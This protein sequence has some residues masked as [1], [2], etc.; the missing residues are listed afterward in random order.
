MTKHLR[1]SGYGLLLQMLLATVF[2]T[3]TAS[4][5]GQPAPQQILVLKPLTTL[6][7]H[8]D[9]GQIAEAHTILRALTAALDNPNQK[10][11]IS[12][13]EW[14]ELEFLR[15]RLAMAEGNFEAAVPI[16]ENILSRY[17]DIARVR[18]ELGMAFFNLKQDQRAHYQFDLALQA[19]LPRLAEA[20]IESV[21]E[22]MYRR[23][24]WQV[25]MKFSLVPDSN[26][27]AATDDRTVSLFG[28]PFVLNENATEQS[29]IG[30]LAELGVTN[31]IHLSTNLTLDSSASV[32][33]IEYAGSRFDDT[34]IS[35]YSGPRHATNT[36]AISLQFGGFRRWFGEGGF[37]RGIGTQLGSYQRIGQKW[38]TG[39]NASLFWVNYD[40]IAPR[41]GFSLQ[42]EPFLVR[43]VGASGHVRA[44]VNYNQDFA[45]EQNQASITYQYGL[46]FVRELP[47]DLRLELNGAYGTRQFQAAQASFGVRRQD[48]FFSAGLDIAFR[49]LQIL[50]AALEFSYKFEKADSNISL[51][52]YSRHRFEVGLTKEF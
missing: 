13:E 36:S 52:S 46:R 38:A 4:A 27:N 34:I 5:E 12:V 35:F 3:I 9:Q 21:K 48:E 25:R 23:R 14:I 41:T 11:A 20:R 45:R 2:L 15:G 19:T 28:L 39:I 24:K 50:D 7:Q 37:N 17:P 47:M 40:Q 18:L 49:K 1:L 44:H 22:A 51:F 8:I 29:G 42:A 30:A 32:R 6:Q 33:R 26:I 31:A 16:F 43:A 10:L